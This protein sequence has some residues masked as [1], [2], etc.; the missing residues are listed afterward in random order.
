M[1]GA[2]WQKQLR[3]GRC[4]LRAATTPAPFLL[5]LPLS[6]PAAV[7]CGRCCRRCWR[8]WPRASRL[9]L[10][11]TPS[12]A[13]AAPPLPTTRLTTVRRTGR[14]QPVQ[15]RVPRTRGLQG[16]PENRLERPFER[17]GAGAVGAARVSLGWS[18]FRQKSASSE[19]SVGEHWR[20]RGARAERRAQ[21]RGAPRPWACSRSS[22]SSAAAAPRFSSSCLTLPAD[23]SAIPA[24]TPRRT[25]HGRPRWPSGVCAQRAAGE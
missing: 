24:D 14:P 7:L 25:R 6:A 1:R 16:H 13:R 12:R 9:T 21:K 15:H 23:R 17:P 4:F 20:R 18:T 11:L 22:P 2:V 3:S 5:P 8:G 19:K 10:T